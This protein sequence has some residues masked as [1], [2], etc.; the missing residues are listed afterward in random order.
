MTLDDSIFDDGLN[1]LT[2]ESGSA[3]LYLC[4]QEPTT[5]DEAA[6]TYK[7]ATKSNVT[8]GSP[9]DASGVRRVT[10][11]A[12]DDG[13]VNTTGTATHWGLV[14]GASDTLL[15]TGAL[16]AS[17]AITSGNEFS[18]DAINIQFTNPPTAV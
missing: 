14:N 10:I 18:L 5:V 17:V 12:I 7:L 2:N 15:A 6:T 8:I 11:A 1:T 13:T 16:D 4:S 3:D 9:A